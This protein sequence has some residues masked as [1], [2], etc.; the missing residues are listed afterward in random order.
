[1]RASRLQF[2]FCLGIALLLPC[3]VKANTTYTFTG[4][5]FNQ[6][7]G[8]TCPP[9]CNI[10]GSITLA[11]PLPPNI[12]LPVGQL[13]GSTSN[14]TPLSF[15]FTDGVT[16]ATN[17][18]CPNDNI[19]NANTDANGNI[20][21]YGINV[22][23]N[24]GGSYFYFFYY[25]PFGTLVGLNGTNNGAFYQAFF[26]DGTAVSGGT[27]S[28]VGCSASSFAAIMQNSVAP[29]DVFPGTISTT[30]QPG[31][32]VGVNV[33]LTAAACRGGYDHFNWKQTVLS[34]SLLDVCPLCAQGLLYL[35]EGSLLL[36]LPHAPFTDPPHG[37]YLY[38]VADKCLPTPPTPI[39]CWFPAR[40]N[41]DWYW[42][43]KYTDK[44]T[45]PD[46]SSTEPDLRITQVDFWKTDNS[47]ITFSDTPVCP[48]ISIGEGYFCTVYFSTNLVG[49]K[50]GTG[51]VL[52]FSGTGFKWHIV[53]TTIGVDARLSTAGSIDPGTLV[54]FDGFKQP[55]AA[56]FTQPELELFAKNGI[57][58]RDE[59][60][61]TTPVIIDIKPGGFPN[62]INPQ[63]LGKIPV[64]IISKTGFL[65]PSQVDQRSLTFG[66]TGN[67]QSLAFC[68]SQDVN[69][70]GI[71]DLVCQFY[72]SLTGFQIGDTAGVL[73]GQ[74]VEG[75]AIFGTDSVVIV[76]PR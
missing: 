13:A 53:G 62:S 33:S 48:L 19:F 74:T 76:P 28:Q 47:L 21:Q 75:M 35:P 36:T 5:R 1:M 44:G 43:E 8:T 25:P 40:D 16:T 66:H 70:D 14:F 68:N 45:L 31:R 24:H 73:K 4:V 71:M 51:D 59:T 29:P 58:V 41:L 32:S 57:N 49:V 17:L 26:N 69:G 7:S 11:Q 6:F 56:G 10:T 9:T 2:A 46:P 63:N 55:G 67:E 54:Y 64:A 39:T 20:T 23:F 27:W 42:D 30:F 60:G 37:G 38:M 52:A 65:A 61:I 22:C 34:D 72:M 15:S 18:T 3:I 50:G 12:N